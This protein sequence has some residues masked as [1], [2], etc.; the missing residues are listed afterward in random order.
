MTGTILAGLVGLAVGSFL[1]IV[2]SRVPREEHFWTGRP[3]CS[4][5]HQTLPWQD[6]VPLLNY[7]W[8]K[9]RC[10]FCG[11]PISWRYPIVEL[12]A[13]VLALALWVH[14][15]GSVLL[16]VYGPFTAALLVLTVLDVQYYWLPDSITLPGIAFGL[17]AAL[18][19]PHLDLGRALL[20]ALGGWALLVAVRWVYEKLT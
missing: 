10:R 1:N 20:G 19:F 7:V 11:D 2:I 9:G 18:I 8:L 17:A 15:P 13:G 12:A 6:F 4:Q 14:F 3:R 16:W 5:F